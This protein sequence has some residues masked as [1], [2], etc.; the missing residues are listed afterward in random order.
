[1]VTALRTGASRTGDVASL[2]KEPVALPELTALSTMLMRVTPT[3]SIKPEGKKLKV[4]IDAAGNYPDWV[5]ALST[6]QT[7]QKGLV[8]DVK[9]ICTSC[10]GK[11]A[12]AEVEPYVQ[13]IVWK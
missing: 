8:W 11:A 7:Y 2:S 1:M 4:W 5:L 13:R 12:Y 3:V 9:V 10:D 6:L